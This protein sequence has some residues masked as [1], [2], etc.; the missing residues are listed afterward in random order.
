MPRRILI[1][2]MSSIGDVIHALPVARALRLAFP[3][4]HVC[5]AVHRSCRDVVEGNR[6]LDE[7]FVVQDKSVR[8]IWQAGRELAGRSF[9]TAIDMQGLFRSGLLAWRSGARERIGFSGN[10]E[11][12][13]LFINRPL[14][15]PGY[16]NTAAY[17]QMEFAAA[18]GASRI[19]PMPEIF[20]APD[21]RAAASQLLAD[22]IASGMPIVALN[23]GT[24]WPTKRWAVEGYAAAADRLVQTTGAR[25][26]ITGALS[27]MPLAR[28]IAQG[29]AHPAS[30]LA[31][32][33]SLK[34]LAAVFERA[35]LYIG[36]DTGPLHIAAA[37][38]TPVVAI[39][40]PTE[41]TW[42]G[43]TGSPSRIIRHKVPCG[44]CRNRQCGHHTCMRLVTVEE[45]VAAATELLAGPVLR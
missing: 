29:M 24:A 4:A 39:F 43:P 30:I 12:R 18:A 23:P 27:D 3:D 1:V 17:C 28:S 2:K 10:Q 44:P 26:V 6:Y 19:D 35:A 38:G 15:K 42:T 40:G 14:V 32:R 22:E 9:D 34:V 31:G 11:M 45:V 33:T 13:Q 16:W 36:G 5:W 37:M 21:H 7:V 41:P 25:I 8:G 20:L